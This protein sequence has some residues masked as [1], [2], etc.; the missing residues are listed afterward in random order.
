MSKKTGISTKYSEF[1][2]VFLSDS[3]AELLEHTGINDH[4]NN[5]LD[6]KQPSYGPIY[7]LRLVE[8]E[9]LKTYIRANLANGFI[10]SSKSPIGTLILL[11]QKKNG[12]LCL[13]INYQRLNNLKIKNCY[14]L[15][16]IGEL[17]DCLGHN[18]HF[19]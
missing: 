9:T 11:I 6:N 5:L 17:L 15:P 1:S 10:R 3:A 16:L 7:S 8:L 2:N 18:Q 4:S 13:C 14:P 19:A 12:S